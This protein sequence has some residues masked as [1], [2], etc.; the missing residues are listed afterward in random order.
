MNPTDQI[1]VL[2]RRIIFA[3]MQQDFT[4][5]LRLFQFATRDGYLLR[6]EISQARERTVQRYSN[7]EFTCLLVLIMFGL[8]I[9]LLQH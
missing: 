3:G 1:L 9:V 8:A 7:L 5:K 4:S 6:V 2:K